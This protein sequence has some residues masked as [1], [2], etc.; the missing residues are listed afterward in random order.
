MPKLKRCGFAT[1]RIFMDL[2]IMAAGMGSRFGGL[3]QIEPVN[4][5]NEFIID[6][7]IYDA[8]RAGFDRV[9]FIIKKEN[10]EIFRNT[11]GKRVEDKIKVEYV[12][13]ELE[14]L[15]YGYEV[16]EGRVKPWGTG[17][18][19]WCCKNVVKDDFAIV[20]ADDF[21]G[22]DAY[23]TASRFIQ[24][25]NN[26]DFGLVAY[27]VK[28]TL[29]EN[30][31]AKRGVCKTFNGKLIDIIESSIEKIDGEIYATPLDYDYTFKID[32]DQIVSM[33]MWC[34]TPKIFKMLDRE[35]PRF[36]TTALEENPLKAEFLLPTIVDK[37]VK[38]GAVDVQVKATTAKWLGVTY[39]EDKE[40][41][42]N[43]LKKLTE[44]KIYP[45]SLWDGTTTNID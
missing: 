15:P 32:E 28:N 4:E 44:R 27:K 13:Q 18:A 35:F 29:S 42:V 14:N 26:Y 23:L 11:V 25:N 5:N 24:A 1:K 10:Y 20:N 34:F 39:K 19:I 6:Y 17:H 33:N 12:F 45:K 9:I 36:L 7:S 30:G 43:G 38:N 41:V 40:S 16:P 3:K 31:S 21:Y 2:V 8:I 37:M 22:L